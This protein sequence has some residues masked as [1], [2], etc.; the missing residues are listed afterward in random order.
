MKEK[1]SPSKAEK[2]K[3]KAEQ[4]A[5]V[6]SDMSCNVLSSSLLKNSRTGNHKL[7]YQFS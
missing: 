4:L 7:V 3:E 5:K 6:C 1:P 2:A